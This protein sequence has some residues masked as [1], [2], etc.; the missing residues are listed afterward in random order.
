MPFYWSPINAEEMKKIKGHYADEDGKPALPVR[1]HGKTYFFEPF[2]AIEIPGTR[3]STARFKQFSAKWGNNI[4]RIVPG[5]DEEARGVRYRETGSTEGVP[6]TKVRVVVPPK[7]V[8]TR[9][10]KDDLHD[11]AEAASVELNPDLTKD[12][13]VAAIDNFRA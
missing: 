13:L 2:T 1:M 8:L 12:E 6:A 7:H 5:T 10:N 4:K 9:L 3:A 11:M